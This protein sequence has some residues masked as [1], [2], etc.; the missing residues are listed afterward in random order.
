[1][2]I[3]MGQLLLEDITA[4]YW[5]IHIRHMDIEK[6]IHGQYLIWNIA[7]NMFLLMLKCCVYPWDKLL[8]EDIITVYWCKHLVHGQQKHYCDQYLSDILSCNMFTHVIHEVCCH[9]LR[10]GYTYMDIE[11]I[12]HAKCVNTCLQMYT[13]RCFIIHRVN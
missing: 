8:L 4:V 7:Y 2:W 12:S 9:V 13:S 3:S 5:D 6:L 1:M 11:D 10:L